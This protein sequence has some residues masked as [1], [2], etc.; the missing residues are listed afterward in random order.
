VSPRARDHFDSL[1]EDAIES[2]PRGV[3]AL[4]DEVTVVALDRP[5][6]EMVEQLR[7]EGTLEPGSDGRDLCGLHTGTAITQRSV[8]SEGGRLPDQVHLFREGIVSL[9]LSTEEEEGDWREWERAVAEGRSGEMDED[10]Y[11]E[12][13]ITLLHEIGHHFGLD[14]AD[15]DELGYA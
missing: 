9:A 15:L 14:E 10:V 13:R 11:E 12:I 8:E 4:L 5:T 2:L 7:R 1:L 3:R 6:A